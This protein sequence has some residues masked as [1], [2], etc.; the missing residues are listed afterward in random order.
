MSE[1]NFNAD[2]EIL[3]D[4]I[5][6]TDYDI[7]DISEN[8][9]LFEVDKKYYFLMLNETKKCFLVNVT[10]ITK[11]S[12]KFVYDNFIYDNKDIFINNV[13][14]M[15]GSNETY[16]DPIA[17][18]IVKF[19]KLVTFKD[20]VSNFVKFLGDEYNITAGTGNK[21]ITYGRSTDLYRLD[22]DFNEAKINMLDTDGKLSIPKIKDF[23]D[24]INNI[25]KGNLND[26]YRTAITSRI[27]IKY[28]NNVYYK[29]E[30]NIYCICKESLINNFEYNKFKMIDLISIYLISYFKKIYKYYEGNRVI[31][32]LADLNTIYDFEFYDN[33]DMFISMV[34]PIKQISPVANIKL[35]SPNYEKLIKFLPTNEKISEIL[36][37]NIPKPI[38]FNYTINLFDSSFLKN[39][40]HNEIK[41]TIFSNL[42]EIKINFRLQ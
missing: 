31:K 33:H 27:L 24:I 9:F 25:I 41:N 40:N 3:Y 10:K 39:I 2:F 20:K 30:N 11:L 36:K 5:I 4:K 42:E 21:I 17:L 14:M 12:N 35:K 18:K 23:C 1:I 19:F 16:S 37:T 38:Y 22:V 29:K 13:N 34:F 7:N 6:L 32:N 26:F 28:E 15:D 8:T